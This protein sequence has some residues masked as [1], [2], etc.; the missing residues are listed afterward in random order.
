MTFEEWKEKSKTGLTQ[1]TLDIMKTATH[2]L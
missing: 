2:K 1:D